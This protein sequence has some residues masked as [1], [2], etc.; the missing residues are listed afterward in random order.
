MRYRGGD[1]PPVRF[2]PCATD[3][4]VGVASDAADALLDE[5]WAKQHVT[6][7]TTGR[8]H[9]VQVE[10]QEHGQDAYWASYWD[11]DDLF[12]GHVLGFKGLER[13]AVVLA[14]NGFRDRTR[15]QEMLY[16]GLSRARDLLVVCG[17]PTLV[18]EVGGEAVA[19]RLG[20]GR[21]G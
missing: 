11:D 13:P 14:V 2:V 1:G 7:L 21:K 16:V 9:P 15:A 4:A 10:R 8:R 5:G 12:Y 17:D 20:C 18:R 3:D 6:L 19:I